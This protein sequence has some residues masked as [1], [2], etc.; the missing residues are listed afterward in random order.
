MAARVALWCSATAALLMAAMLVPG[1]GLGPAT[2]VA[3][4]SVRQMRTHLFAGP[5]LKIE[6]CVS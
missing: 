5:V 4:G 2:A 3:D 6:Y 1:P